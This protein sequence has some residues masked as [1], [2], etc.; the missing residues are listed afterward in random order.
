MI[1]Q[2]AI[3]QYKMD[4]IIV[5]VNINGKILKIITIT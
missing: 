5:T 3:I 2:G 4:N 1:I